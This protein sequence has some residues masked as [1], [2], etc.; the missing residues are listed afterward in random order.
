MTTA[1]G[2]ELQAYIRQDEG[3]DGDLAFNRCSRCGCVMFWCGVGEFAGLEHEMGV[4]C[5]MLPLGDVE[6][7]ERRVSRKP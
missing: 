4:N 1:A 5:R 7:I 2:T 3:S 6:G